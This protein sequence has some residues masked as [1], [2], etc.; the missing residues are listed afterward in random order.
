MSRIRQKTVRE[1]DKLYNVWEQPGRERV[2]EQAERVRN[3]GGSRPMKWGQLSASIP[4]LDYRLMT[5]DNPELACADRKVQA[6]A[7]SKFLSSSEGRKYSTVN[8][9]KSRGFVYMGGRRNGG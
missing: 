9:G 7:W 8:R 1:G 6:R 2:L 3:G 5:R 4:E